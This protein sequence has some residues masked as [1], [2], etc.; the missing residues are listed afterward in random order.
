MD[1]DAANL[2]ERYSM[3]DLP[4]GKIVAV[5]NIVCICKSELLDLCIAQT[6]R[7]FG[8]YSPERFGWILNDIRP[9]VP[10]DFRGGQGIFNVDEL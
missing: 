5:A 9:V 6:E 3:R 7:D 1:M 10:V 8:I 2:A 4:Y